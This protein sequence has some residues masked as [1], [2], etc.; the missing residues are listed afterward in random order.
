MKYFLIL[1]TTLLIAGTTWAQ[2]C[3]VTS[4]G[5]P[6]PAL[7][8]LFD[9]LTKAADAVRDAKTPQSS[10]EAWFGLNMVADEFAEALNHLPVSGPT[11][12]RTSA[13]TLRSAQVQWA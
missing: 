3:N 13:L 11:K 7:K 2:R 6:D 10:A 9:K 4:G 5:G 1:I 8:P 12:I